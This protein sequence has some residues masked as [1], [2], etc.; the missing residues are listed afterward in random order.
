MLNSTNWNNPVVYFPT[1]TKERRQVSRFMLG[2]EVIRGIPKERFVEFRDWDMW[3]EFFNSM[4]EQEFHFLDATYTDEEEEDCLENKGMVNSFLMGFYKHV[5]HASSRLIPIGIELFSKSD[6]I[7][8][9]PK[10]SQ[11]QLRLSTESLTN[12]Y[13]LA[14]TAPKITIGSLLTSSQRESL[15]KW[16]EITEHHMSV[17][18][19]GLRRFIPR[20]LYHPIE[21]PTVVDSEKDSILQKAWTT[22]TPK[23]GLYLIEEQDI[24]EG[25]APLHMVFKIAQRLEAAGYDDLGYMSRTHALKELLKEAITK[26]PSG[27]S[28]LFTDALY[29]LLSGE[30]MSIGSKKAKFNYRSAFEDTM[31]RTYLY[32]QDES[33]HVE[34]QEARE[35]ITAF[36]DVFHHHTIALSI[37]NSYSNSDQIDLRRLLPTLDVVDPK[38]AKAVESSLLDQRNRPLLLSDEVQKSLRSLTG[39]PDRGDKGQDI[40]GEVDEIIADNDSYSFTISAPKL[41]YDIPR[42]S[43]YEISIT[44]DALSQKISAELSIESNRATKTLPYTI[45]YSEDLICRTQLLDEEALPIEVR[46]E[47]VHIVERAIAH[48]AESLRKKAAS[49]GVIFTARPANTPSPVSQKQTREERMGEY[50]RLRASSGRKRTGSTE[51]TPAASQVPDGKD[52]EKGREFQLRI[53]GLDVE[54]ISSIMA[55]Q[56]IQGIDP[57]LIIRKLNHMMENARVSQQMIGKR[58]NLD[59]VRDLPAEINIRQL[60]WMMDGG[61]NG[62]RVYLEDIGGGAFILRGMLNKKGLSQQQRYIE[63]MALRIL[64]ERRGQE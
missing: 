2:K 54:T 42:G 7:S 57:H 16:P 36:K 20:W 18:R 31:V 23:E 53:I 34:K 5:E 24:H 8:V 59:T 61:N 28:E 33:E 50:Q 47:L 13:A 60:N 39:E 56:K 19:D 9:L 32:L 48:H 10:P 46:G 62:L 38:F 41:G 25:K 35:L 52:I 43:R 21:R 6:K 49:K 30:G 37:L 14:S 40:A 17:V 4:R 58:I 1:M 44:I 45:D 26:W 11:T 63:N 51:I 27:N 55:Q 64:A 15:R 29:D 3:E 22:Y 12:Y